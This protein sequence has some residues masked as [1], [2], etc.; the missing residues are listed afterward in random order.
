VGEKE[1]EEGGWMDGLK[2]RGERGG[3]SVTADD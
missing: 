2:K 1:G 3:D